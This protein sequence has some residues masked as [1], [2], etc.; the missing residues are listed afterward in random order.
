VIS[1]EVVWG[2]GGQNYTSPPQ[3]S[4][5]A[6]FEGWKINYWPSNP[7]FPKSMGKCG[8]KLSQQIK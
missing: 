6:H 2:M 8:N 4:T 7:T 1:R 5:K 3:L